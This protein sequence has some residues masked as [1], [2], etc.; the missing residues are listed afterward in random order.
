METVAA[1]VIQAAVRRYLSIRC[2]EKM[3]HQT[4]AS[5]DK[6]VTAM[7]NDMFM[8][9]A[10]R[11]QSVFRGFWARDCIDVDHFC[12]SSIQKTF[13]AYSARKRA[14]HFVS[15]IIRIQAIWRRGIARAHAANYLGNIVLIQALFRSYCVRKLMTR[16]RAAIRQ[17]IKSAQIPQN[18]KRAVEPP[19]NRAS[20]SRRSIDPPAMRSPSL[21]GKVS[22]AATIIQAWW[23]MIRSENMFIR[24]LVDI[25]IV[26][27][28]IRSWIARRR[29]NE[30]REVR[31][32]HTRNMSFDSQHSFR[33]EDTSVGSDKPDDEEM[34]K[35]NYKPDSSRF[36]PVESSS[37]PVAFSGTT[38]PVSTTEPAVVVDRTE[39]KSV[40]AF[41]KDRERQNRLG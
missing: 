23:R 15:V 10:I 22:K 3:R 11:I 33:R 17:Q 6:T 40:L 9:A 34:G 18:Q 5:V 38:M 20:L 2:V 25:L 21:G 27:T 1:I 37:R 13:R 28:V 41:W 16:Y 12:A 26:Q 29:V 31:R 14:Q 36:T 39:R 30:L 32:S 24:S 4:V 8:L 7:G 19:A 35:T